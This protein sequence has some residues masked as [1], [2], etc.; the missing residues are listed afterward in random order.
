[1]MSRI[2]ELYYELT[3]GNPIEEIEVQRDRAEV[4][5]HRMSEEQKKTMSENEYEEYV[6]KCMEMVEMGERGG[7]IVG[8]SYAVQ[9][10]CECFGTRMAEEQKREQFPYG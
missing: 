4:E 9:I 5:V 2:E 10:V 6:G 7:F 1:M 8:F 3:R